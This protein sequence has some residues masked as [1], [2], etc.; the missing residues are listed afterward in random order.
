MVKEN[1]VPEV[2]TSGYVKQD[3]VKIPGLFIWARAGSVFEI[4]PRHPFLGKNFDVFIIIIITMICMAQIPYNVQMRFTIK[5][6]SPK[7]SD[8]IINTTIRI[9]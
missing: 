3:K 7:K 1:K 8:T 6:H 2:I 9:K 5:L 4:S